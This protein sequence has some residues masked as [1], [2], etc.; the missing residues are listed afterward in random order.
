MSDE[1]HSFPDGGTYT[2]PLGA[3]AEMGPT[4]PS[5]EVVSDEDNHPPALEI[6]LAISEG[7]PASQVGGVSQE[8]DRRV[9]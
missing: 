9:S 5:L 1:E 7:T 2:E 6:E 8:H 3:Q 4:N